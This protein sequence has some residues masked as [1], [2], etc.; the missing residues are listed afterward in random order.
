MS[1]RPTRLPSTESTR[2]RRPSTSIS[3]PGRAS[4]SS[5]STTRP[6]MDSLCTSSPGSRPSSS[7]STRGVSPFATTAPDERRRMPAGRS[8]SSSI[9][10][11]ISSTMS[12]TVTTPASVPY[13]STMAAIDAR[14]RCRRAS[15]RSSGMVSG[16]IGISCTSVT[17]SS[18]PLPVEQGRRELAGVDDAEQALVLGVDHRRARAPGVERPAQ[19]RLDRLA[20]LGQHEAPPR[21]HHVAGAPLVER[22]GAAQDAGVGLVH[23]AAAATRRR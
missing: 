8:L 12:S 4:R 20:G 14:S 23:A 19:H 13:S 3:S 21:R 11:T 16:A 2:M 15:S 5:R 6:P 18:A 7:R 1:T 17:T 10:P 22:E 9:S